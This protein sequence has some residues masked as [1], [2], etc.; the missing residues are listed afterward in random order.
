MEFIGYKIL[1]AF[2]L[3]AVIGM[4]REVSKNSG[5]YKGKNL[6]AILG[7]RTFSLV[8]VLGAISGILYVSFMPLALIISA[9]FFLILIVF[10]FL[11]SS[12]TKDHGITSEIALMYS[13]VIGILLTLDVIPVQLTLAI[14]VGV[15]LL[16]SQ[17]RFIKTQIK[18]VQHYELNAF[19]SFAI[20]ALAIL[21]FLPNTSYALNDIPAIREFMKNFGIS[22]AKFLATDFINP[23]KLWMYVALITGVDLI[24]YLLERSIGQKKGWLLAS[25][26]GGFVSSTATTQSLAQESK[27]RKAV[28]VLVAA[29]ILS[30]LVSFIQIGILIM[31]VN[32]VFFVQLLP[33]LVTMILASFLTLFYFLKKGEKGDKGFTGSGKKETKIIDLK[34]ALKFAVL[35]LI[36]TI[37]SKVALALF[38]SSGFLI[39]TA[40]GAFAGLDAVIINAANLSGRT[41]EESLAVLAFIIANASNLGA[42]VFYSFGMGSRNF[43]V[44][45]GISMLIIIV[46]SLLAF[47]LF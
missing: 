31:P 43:T 46:A 47:F 22:D 34:A 1:L 6:P 7:I 4:E 23:F 42:K 45:L 30:N 21:P 19:I 44:K 10:Y 37:I 11:D 39:T 28:N 3:G 25:M 20:I 14:T 41:I 8:T 9:A 26:A 15:I 16:L 2:L 24:G 40:I 29:A 5:I 12:S 17:K 33:I 38:G 27:K 32:A 35:F 36:I 18:N 13:Y